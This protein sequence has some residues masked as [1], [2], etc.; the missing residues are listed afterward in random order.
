[1]PRWMKFVDL[2]TVRK[3]PLARYVLINGIKFGVIATLLFVVTN[4]IGDVKGV[5]VLRLAV[6]WGSLSLLGALCGAGIWLL[7]R[8][9]L[10]TQLAVT[11][12]SILALAGI[13]LTLVLKLG[14]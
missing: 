2:T 14:H 4:V 10:R 8:T 6:A 5:T 13:A 11:G 3:Q 12:L 9:S 1:M 7:A